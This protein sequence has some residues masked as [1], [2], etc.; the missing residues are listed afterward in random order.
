MFLI[1]FDGAFIMLSE[2]ITKPGATSSTEYASP[3]VFG[4]LDL[5]IFAALFVS[6]WQYILGWRAF[7]SGI[8][9]KDDKSNMVSGGTSSILTESFTL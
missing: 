8:D 4:G 2:S 3:L 9:N 7:R 5:T 6:F 1:F